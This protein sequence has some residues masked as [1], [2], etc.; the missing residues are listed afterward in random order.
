MP[1]RSFYEI[2]GVEFDATEEDIKKAYRKRA[3]EFH[4]DK[5]PGDSE[6]ESKF[7]ELGSAYQVLSDPQQRERYDLLTARFGRGRKPNAQS[8]PSG[9]GQGI[10][11]SLFETLLGEIFNV[12]THSRPRNPRH[13]VDS[14]PA[15]T[16]R[17]GE[18]VETEVHI[19]LEE[20]AEGCKKRILVRSVDTTITCTTC[21]GSGGRPGGPA[22]PCAACSGKGKQPHAWNKNHMIRCPAC[23]GRGSTPILKCVSCGGKGSVRQDKEIDVKIPAGVDSGHKLRLAGA[24]SPG[25]QSAPGDL[26]LIIRIIEHPSIVRKGKHLFVQKRVKL[27]E[28]LRGSE[29]SV[30]TIG[31]KVV[32]FHIPAGSQPGDTITIHG[33]GI[34]GIT[35]KLCGDLHITINAWLPKPTTARGMK[36][37][38]ELCEEL[39]K[40]GPPRQEKN[41]GDA[42][43][44]VDDF[45]DEYLNGTMGVKQ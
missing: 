11:P 37:L 36:L 19:T 2:L 42:A 30:E 1:S 4:P 44:D 14:E 3:S 8:G 6:A 5:N 27:T 29:S 35:D 25:Y 21:L 26:F 9:F 17:P 34:V 40:S 18:D 43:E 7:K 45:I 33:A 15:Q 31:N 16:P 23:K 28:L 22:S 32:D 24:G 10:D 20:A 12:G 13:R 39:D 38:E 41:E